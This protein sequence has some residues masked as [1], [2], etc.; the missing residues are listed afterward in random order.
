MDVDRLLVE[1]FRYWLERYSIQVLT[2]AGTRESEN[3]GIAEFTR[4]FLVNSLRTDHG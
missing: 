2:V 3:P 4:R 1:E